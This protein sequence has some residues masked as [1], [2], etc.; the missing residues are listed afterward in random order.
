MYAQI[1]IAAAVADRRLDFGSDLPA[2]YASR[3]STT[4]ADHEAVASME[5]RLQYTAEMYSDGQK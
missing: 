3:L 4:D 1:T 5:R 2:S